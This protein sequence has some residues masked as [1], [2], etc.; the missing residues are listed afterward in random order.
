MIENLRS[1]DIC[2]PTYNRRDQ[3]NKTINKLIEVISGSIY[4]NQIKI[5]ISNNGSSDDTKNYLDSIDKQYSFISI[6]HQ[7]L[8][9]G[10]V[11]NIRSLWSKSH[12]TYI[13]T[14]SDDD[15]YSKDLIEKI[16][17]ESI[18]D[19][20][21]NVFIL[22]SF[23]FIESEGLEKI[24]IH[25]NMLNLS[26]EFEDK[27]IFSC[28]LVD[29][30]NSENFS[31]FGLLSSIVF[32]RYLIHK[33]L[34]DHSASKTNYPHQFLLFSHC[35]EKQLKIIN[36]DGGLGWRAESSNWSTE[37]VLESFTAHYV[38]YLEIL[39]ASKWISK[40]IAS[41]IY[42]SIYK[43]SYK[44]ILLYLISYKKTSV[45]VFSKI[46]VNHLK[47]GICNPKLDISLFFIGLLNIVKI[48]NLLKSKILES[49]K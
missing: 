30:V 38:D 13:W 1:I 5:I 43:N 3:L 31:A 33:F 23:H 15:F 28:T 12:A 16:I 6:L 8:N 32:P 44:A 17:F 39:G 7:N 42:G 49:I 40:N 4:K 41:N 19:G 27:N 46:F 20:N 2:V 36:I 22:N 11:E 9:I 14:I 45:W 21:S 26:S 47:Y 24:Y 25:K 29:I 34:L 48:R 35:G 10:F 37:K 18:V